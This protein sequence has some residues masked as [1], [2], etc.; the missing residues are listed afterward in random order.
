MP[1]PDPEPENYSIDDMM[2][3]LRSRGEGGSDGE[4]QLVTREDGTQVYRM[5]KRKRRSQQPK[6]DKDRRKKQFRVVQVVA[7]VGLVAATGAA[8]LASFLYLNS[9]VY[10]D[11]M[12]QRIGTWTGAEPK[13]TELRLTPVSVAA[14]SLELK[15]PEG[16][17][18]D[19]LKLGAIGGD[20]QA[21]ALLGGKWKGNELYSAHGGTLVLRKPTAGGG[22]GLNLPVGT[23]CPFQ[24]RYR[25]SKFSVLSGDPAKPAFLIRDSEASLLM[26]N[27][28]ADAANL[29]IE[30]GSLRVGGW[31]EYGLGFASL[32][33]G[34]GTV[35]VGGLRLTPASGG[36]GELRIDNPGEKPF[37]FSG[38]T[39][40][41]GVKLFQM[42]L[43][44]LLGPSFG[45]W[46]SMTVETP[47]G[48][49]G[50]TLSLRLGEAP[51]MSLRVPFRALSTT[52]TEAVGLPM[53]EV[54][55][56]HL[57]EPWYQS[58]RFEVEAK[59]EAVKTAEGSGV[60]NLKLEA[61]GRL[62][63]NGKVFAK[64]DGTL[65]G[66]LEV[67]LPASAVANASSELR[68]VFSKKSGGWL[69]ATV[70]VSGN[71]RS[72]QDN[73]EAQLGSSA[74]TVS[75]A[76]GGNEALEDAFEELTT[77]GAK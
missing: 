18:L 14:S 7:A 13:V 70:K 32:Q 16:S 60:E 51:S 44:A 71:S 22:P 23:E 43:A 75:P 37:D 21:G 62:A 33:F 52:D 55:A 2:D 9:G 56:T 45:S 73:L 19:S 27:S 76:Q 72:P 65:D 8:F 20:L 42:P 77:P 61:R 46:L 12:V 5:R 15:W 69:W 24:F 41:L 67:G 28:A 3:R 39:S 17:A 74:A 35:R 36:K 30:G 66:T 25:S 58:P 47:E 50:G 59:G 11:S 34:K 40:E 29:Q 26:L 31:G 63:L 57:Q 6:K 4:A 49:E 38:G 10:K 64:P 68:S 1:S 53:F 54:L 48:A